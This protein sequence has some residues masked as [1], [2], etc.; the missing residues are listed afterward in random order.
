[1]KVTVPIGVPAPG[2]FTATVALRVT[3]CPVTGEEGADVTAVVVAARPTVT[4]LVP[5]EP[6]SLASPP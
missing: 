3:V 6:T 4:E 1:V 5:E 2:G